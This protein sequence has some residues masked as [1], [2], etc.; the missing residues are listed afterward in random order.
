[1][2]KLYRSIFFTPRFFALCGLLVLMALLSWKWAFLYGITLSMVIA[3]PFVLAADFIMLWIHKGM[4]ARREIMEKLSNGD[5]NDIRIYIENK[6]PYPIWL[7]V[8]D[9]LPVQ[10]QARDSERK[11][12]LTKCDLYEEVSTRSEQ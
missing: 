4:F 9:E 7:K 8:V 10:F 3:V 6:Y 12:S 1:M 5:Q 11:C 2:L